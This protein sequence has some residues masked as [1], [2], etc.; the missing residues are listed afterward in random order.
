MKSTAKLKE[1]DL[2]PQVKRY[3]RRL[4]QREQ[5]A[6]I[7]KYNAYPSIHPTIGRQYIDVMEQGYEGEF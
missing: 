2:D 4:S 5:K 7:Q 6:W 3:L 1:L